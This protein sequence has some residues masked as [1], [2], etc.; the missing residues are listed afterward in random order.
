MKKATLVLMAVTTGLLFSCNKENIIDSNQD[1]QGGEQQMQTTNGTANVFSSADLI[2]YPFLTTRLNTQ[3]LAQTL[4]FTDAN[5]ITI[6]FRFRWD[7]CFRPLGICIA[8]VFNKVNEP[9]TPVYVPNGYAFDPPSED[10]EGFANLYM[11][12]G[13][14]ILFPDQKISM[15]D[16]GSVPVTDPIE[17]DANT[18]AQLGV[19]ALTIQPGNY[20]IHN[21]YISQDGDGITYKG[22]YVILNYE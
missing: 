21:D 11:V 16:G 1:N 4:D 9:A 10:G 19:E 20:Q 6:K 8:I 3:P 18:C 5:S 12:D 13:Q 7:G 22:G 15:D 17:L 14:L 2:E